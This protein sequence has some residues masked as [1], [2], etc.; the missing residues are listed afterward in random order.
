LLPIHSIGT[1]NAD[2]KQ[3]HRTRERYYISLSKIRGELHLKL[4]GSILAKKKRKNDLEKFAARLAAILPKLSMNNILRFQ[5]RFLDIPKK[6]ALW[7]IQAF[8]CVDKRKRK[9]KKRG[10][11]TIGR[12]TRPVKF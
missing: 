2:R 1:A 6:E 11:H 3:D 12:F 10:N 5:V 4:S 9:E 7:N 8:Y